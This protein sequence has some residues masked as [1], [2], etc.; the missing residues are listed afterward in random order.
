MSA[1][2]E[3]VIESPAVADEVE[4]VRSPLGD[5]RVLLHNISWET[6]ERLLADMENQSY[7]RMTYDQ[8]E[9]EI[10][11]PSFNHEF[12]NRSIAGLGR[13]ISLEMDVEV[14]DA[15]STTY[16]RK[17]LKRGAEPDTCFYVANALL[18]HGRTEVDLSR[19]PPPD[20]VFEVDVFS[21]SLDKFSIYA[22]FGVPELWHYDVRQVQIFKLEGKSYVECEHSLSFPW[23]TGMILTGFLD[24]CRSVGQ[25]AAIRSFRDWLRK[26]RPKLQA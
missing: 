10:M 12:F 3:A 24:Q 22:K 9:L 23:L 11:A 26:E 8:G 19:D 1:T 6:Y 16:K 25:D 7:I 2:M 5:Q 14:I 17:R 4:V 13:I 15:G 18:M 20:I 21:G